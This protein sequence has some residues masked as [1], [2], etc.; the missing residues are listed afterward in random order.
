V[1]DHVSDRPRDP[2]REAIRE[3]MGDF[4]AGPEPLEPERP[5]EVI[6]DAGALL[7]IH[8]I[9]KSYRR[10][11]E[12]VHALRRVTLSVRPRELVALVGPSGSGKTTLLSILAGWEHPDR[13]E[14]LWHAEGGVRP[15]RDLSWRDLAIVPQSLGLVEELSVREN[16]ALPLRLS[17]GRAGAMS[18]PRVDALLHALGLAE[19]AD[20]APF[21]V[22]IGEQQRTAIARA[23]VVQ[24][25]LLVADEPTGHQDADWA[26]GV[27]RALREAAGAGTACLVATHNQEAVKY[28]HRVLEIRD[29]RLGALTPAPAPEPGP[30]WAGGGGR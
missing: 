14:M 7:E 21:E 24:P 17:G 1:T 27:F 6:G 15:A 16:I 28:M 29:G 13:G 23:L 10:G 25:R 2:A 19:L 3:A 22:S 8:G 5:A 20:R 4:F 18:D 26:H 12:E 11:P 9:D 30:S